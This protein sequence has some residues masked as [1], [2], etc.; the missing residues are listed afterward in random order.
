MLTKNTVKETDSSREAIIAAREAKKLAKQKA[1]AKDSNASSTKENVHTSENTNPKLSGSKPNVESLK[2]EEVHI[3]PKINPEG[4]DVPKS[5]DEVDRAASVVSENIVVDTEKSKEAIKAER[6]AKK[7]AKQAKKKSND[8]NKLDNDKPNNDSQAKVDSVEN[9]SNNDK[10]ANDL[11]VR[12]VYDTLKDIVSVAKDVQAV[13]DKVIA[14]DLG[15]KKVILIK[16]L[17]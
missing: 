17:W 3:E 9:K 16:C 12:E 7:A 11:T 15:H 10:P 13:T 5:K 6:A 1:K 14:I 8:N 2:N 4:K